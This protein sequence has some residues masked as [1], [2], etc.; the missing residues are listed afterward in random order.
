MFLLC[1]VY[2][3]S[4]YVL[5]DTDIFSIGCHREMKEQVKTMSYFGAFRTQGL[6]SSLDDWKKKKNTPLIREQVHVLTFWHA[7]IS[8]Q[9]I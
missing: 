3:L 9:F 6:Q 5:S 1:R 7:H 8:R 2:L 4:F